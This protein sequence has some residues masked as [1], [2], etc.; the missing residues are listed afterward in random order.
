MNENNIRKNITYNITYNL[1]NF[2]TVQGKIALT[3][4]IASYETIKEE[5]YLQILWRTFR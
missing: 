5:K 3:I 2:E 4:L 1:L